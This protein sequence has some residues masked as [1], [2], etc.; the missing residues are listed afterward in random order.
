M[1]LLLRSFA[2]HSKSNLIFCR[3]LSPLTLQRY[4]A[5]QKR[6][7]NALETSRNSGG[8]TVST[9]VRPIGEKVK[10]AAKTTSYLGVIVLGVGVT[11]I[12]FYA[13]FRELFSSN[14]P[15]AI[16]TEAF[17]KCKAVSRLIQD[18]YSH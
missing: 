3:A 10:E 15:N 16:Y 17:E 9:D 8:G 18:S 14:S 1:A 4:Y 13:I 7:D 2:I 6:N 5:S 12:M 11:G